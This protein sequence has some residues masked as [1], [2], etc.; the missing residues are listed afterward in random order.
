M[1]MTWEEYY[2]NRIIIKSVLLSIGLI[3]ILIKV[4]CFRKK[5]KPIN[6]VVEENEASQLPESNE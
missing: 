4:C 1:G 3:L 5:K 2:R 6:T